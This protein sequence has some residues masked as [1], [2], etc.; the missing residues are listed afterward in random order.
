M[1]DSITKALGAG[2]GIDIQ[3]LVASLVDA[4]YSVKTKQVET[5]AETLTAQV[6]TVSQL[7]SG[8][9]SFA[10]ALATLV[11]G[12]TLATA[13][14]SS[15][16][17]IVKATTLPGA[18]IR[19]L[20][21]TVEVRALA[22][23][24]VAV[25]K[26]GRPAGEPIGTGSIKIDFIG[27]A[28]DIP[29][30][31]IGPDDQTLA[32]IAAKINAAVPPTGLTASVITDTGGERLILKGATGAARAF[33][34]T[35]TA[36]SPLAAAIDVGGTA[37]GTTIETSAADARVA[38]DGVEVRRPTN[39]INDLVP[40]VRLD[41]QSVAIGTRV[42]LGTAPATAALTQAVND[43]VT[44]YNELY[45]V[46][47]DATDP[48][49]GPLAR[50]LGAREMKRQLANLTLTDLTGSSGN[51]LK[52][53]AEIGVG[54]TRDGSLSVNSARLAKVLAENPA[55]VE[56]MF[57]DRGVGATG[58]GLSAS[59]NALS[60]SVASFTVGLGASQTRYSKAQSTLTADKAKIAE[61]QV[62]LKTRLTQQYASMDARVAAYRS[63]QTFITQQVD[64]WNKS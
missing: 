3:S 34:V 60:F 2:S 52:S 41:L 5:K 37:T 18:Q 16:T 33:T 49:T 64:A 40:G 56:A 39:S 55:G 25:T 46:L 43:V 19:T 29:A 21:S 36:G 54:T 44:T 28:V 8:I 26:E 61:E 31:E 15:N 4:Q 30:V 45:K 24:Q 38:I 14:T 27:D 32:G 7:K 47:R 51:G 17:G 22:S 63:T 62:K 13:A 42:T 6:S 48:V 23:A 12:G 11:K 59:L 50:D 35:A 20:D 58:K 1:V 53:L 10:S 9:T 57:T